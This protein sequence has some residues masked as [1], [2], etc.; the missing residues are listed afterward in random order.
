MI[1]GAF[2]DTEAQFFLFNAS[3]LII[4]SKFNNFGHRYDIELVVL[5]NIKHLLWPKNWYI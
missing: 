4:L 5:T 1:F 3:C 2:I